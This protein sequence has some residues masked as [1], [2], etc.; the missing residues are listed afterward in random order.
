MM[1]AFAQQFRPEGKNFSVKYMPGVS[2]L[3]EGGEETVLLI[4]M[5]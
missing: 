3:E 5:A 1:Y 2:R 4:T